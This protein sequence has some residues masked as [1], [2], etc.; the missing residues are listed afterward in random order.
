MINIAADSQIPEIENLLAEFFDD[1]YS[2]KSFDSSIVSSSDFKNIDALLVRSTLFIDEGICADTR[3]RYVGSATAGMNHLDIDYLDA[4]NISWSHAPGCNAFS[5][6]H[7]VMAAIG[8][9]I[10]DGLFNTSQSIGIVGYGNIGRRLYKILKA[11]NFEVYACDPFLSHSELV[12]LDSILECDL[13]T[14]HAPLT[15]ADKHPTFNLINESHIQKVSNK[16]LINTSRGEI[17]SEAFLFKANDL[18]Y[19]SDV[20]V[21]EPNPSL[22]IIKKSY[23]ATPHIAGYSID[24]KLNG[25]KIIAKECA[26]A[27]NCLKLKSIKPLMSPDWPY[28]L[29]NI[30]TD[31]HRMSFPATLFHKELDLKLISDAFKALSSKDLEKGFRSL[32]TNHPP[33]HDFNCYSF[34]GM[35]KLDK[36]IDLQFFDELRRAGNL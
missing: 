18:I 36:D 8:E 13:I 22:E 33:R 16:I 29:Q 25:A 27:F 1:N 14:I 12:N 15:E 3:I 7:Y 23:I 4:Q 9:L 28:E 24:G 20:W 10:K 5:V 21:N 35:S 11:L 31:I 17:I 2:F 26:E 19:I 6:I 32:R 34:R 30:I